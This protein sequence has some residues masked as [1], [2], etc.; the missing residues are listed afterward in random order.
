[1][2]YFVE[3]TY[4]YK[5][6]GRFD[7]DHYT[8]VHIPLAEAQMAKGGLAFKKRIFKN[9]TD[10]LFTGAPVHAL[11]LIYVLEDQADLDAFKAFMTTDFVQPLLEDA[12]SYTDC[13]LLW[14]SG[15]YREL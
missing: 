6:G 15:E 1:M 13:E 3:A 5:S 11:S 7:Y 14:T 4:I 12:K 9:R 8:N 2:T 10:N